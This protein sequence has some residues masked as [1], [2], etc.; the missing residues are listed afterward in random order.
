MTSRSRFQRAVQAASD[1]ARRPVGPSTA[2]ARCPS[3]RATSSP[4]RSSS[5][6]LLAEVVDDPGAQDRA[7]ADPARP[8]DEGEPGR[9]Q[10]RDQDRALGVAAEEEGGVLL[11]ERQQALVRRRPRRLRPGRRPRAGLVGRHRLPHQPTPLGWNRSTRARSRP[12]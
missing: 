3:E 11:G 4:M 12:M 1:A 7:L 2:A 6:L 10:V 9:H 8:V 5:R